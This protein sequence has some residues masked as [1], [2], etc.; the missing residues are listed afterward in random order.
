MI[1]IRGHNAEEG[2]QAHRLLAS[3]S[4]EVQNAEVLERIHR[5]AIMTRTHAALEL[6]DAKEAP[7]YLG[8]ESKDVVVT[9]P[10]RL[11]KGWIAEGDAVGEPRREGVE[12][13]LNLPTRPKGVHPGAR[14]YV[15]AHGRVRG[16]AP[17]H[18]ID[19]DPQ[20]NGNGVL[21]IRRGGAVAV[22]IDEKIKGFQSYR[23]RWWN[24][25]AEKPFPN[26]KTP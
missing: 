7:G 8:F 15:V 20:S 17:L 2:S 21:L 22:T 16:Y 25:D 11:W 1:N 10:A 26:W 3:W 14:V 5:P 4:I 24:L 12:Y 9:V 13:W 18:R 19:R 6:A 23:Y